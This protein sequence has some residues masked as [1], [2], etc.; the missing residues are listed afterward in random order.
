VQ[1]VYN[2]AS[3]TTANLGLA[4]GFTM[5]VSGNLVAFLVGEPGQGNRD[6]NG[7]GDAS[8]PV[9][10][11]YDAA[12]GTTTNLRLAAQDF[13]VGDNLVASRVMEPGQGNTDLN[14]DGDKSDFV[15]H[16]Y[17]PAAGTANLRLAATDYKVQGKL[18][19]FAVLEQFQ[20]N[21]DLNGD[22]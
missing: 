11:V 9:P 3:G 18:A 2:A 19:A 1:H 13:Q 10:H 6:L 7:D 14:G 22:G 16:T 4:S 8:D 17:A 20:G 15:F 21:Q 5:Q 12:T